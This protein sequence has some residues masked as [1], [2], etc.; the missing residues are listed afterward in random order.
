MVRYWKAKGSNPFVVI[1]NEK[2]KSGF[3][4]VQKDSMK[5]YSKVSDR[6]IESQF[7]ECS[8]S[9]YAEYKTLKDIQRKKEY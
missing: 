3:Y 6:V 4:T 9:K 5:G 8:K 1:T 7:E 2:P